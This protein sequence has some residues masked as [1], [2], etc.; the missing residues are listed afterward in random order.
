[1]DRSSVDSRQTRVYPRY[2]MI[3][4]RVLV[5]AVFLGLGGTASAQ[6]TT[7]SQSETRS[8]KNDSASEKE[9][10]PRIDLASDIDRYTKN[11]DKRWRKKLFGTFGIAEAHVFPGRE[12]GPYLGPPI[13]IWGNGW[14]TSMWRDPVTGWPIQ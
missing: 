2:V 9:K 5:L 1:V 11:L 6:K 12:T 8:E 4:A 3:R 7:Q 10:K 14:G 13:R